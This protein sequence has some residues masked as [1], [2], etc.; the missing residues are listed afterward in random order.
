MGNYSLKVQGYEADEIKTPHNVVRIDNAKN[1]IH[2][3]I[4]V[5]N[6]LNTGIDKK[7]NPLKQLTAKLFFTFIPQET[8]N[9]VVSSTLLKF[10][11]T[12]YYTDSRQ[13]L[14]YKISKSESLILNVDSSLS[15]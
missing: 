10:A 15:K 3:S 5:L 9:Q 13:F 6:N 7:E 11:D 14:I 2:W 4:N 12:V 8:G 1:V